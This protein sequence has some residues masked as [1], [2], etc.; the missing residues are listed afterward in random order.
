V[1][2]V[3]FFFDGWE[4]VVWHVVRLMVFASV[5]VHGISATPLTRLYGRVAGEQTELE[6]EDEGAVVGSGPM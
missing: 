3:V 2:P 1:D 5:V 4:P 6:V